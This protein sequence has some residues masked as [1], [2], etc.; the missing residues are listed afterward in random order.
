MPLGKV[1][2]NF[3]YEITVLRETFLSAIT[4]LYDTV[5][6]DSAL[7]LLILLF[8]LNLVSQYYSRVNFQSRTVLHY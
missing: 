4:A 7:T 8:D 1:G 2:S 5:D 3:Y 6:R